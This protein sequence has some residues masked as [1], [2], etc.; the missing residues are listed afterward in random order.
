MPEL[1]PDAPSPN[2]P[3]AL[4]TAQANLRSLGTEIRLRDGSFRWFNPEEAGTTLH[5]YVQ[6]LAAVGLCRTRTTSCG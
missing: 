5:A 4:G 6:S 1:T 2:G 3:D